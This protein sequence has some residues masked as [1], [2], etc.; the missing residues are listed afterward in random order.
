L[1]DGAHALVG[2][3]SGERSAANEQ[4]LWVVASGDRRDRLLDSLAMW[5]GTDFSGG[6]A[7]PRIARSRLAM[8]RSSQP[9]SQARCA[10]APFWEMCS[11]AGKLAQTGQ[12]AMPS[13]GSQR[14]VAARVASSTV[15]GALML[16]LPPAGRR[17]GEISPPTFR[18]SAMLSTVF[19]SCRRLFGLVDEPNEHPSGR[20]LKL[21]AAGGDE[22]VDGRLYLLIRPT[23]EPGEVIE[24][25]ALVDLVALAQA[26]LERLGAGVTHVTRGPR[27][28]LAAWRAS[29]LSV[30]RRHRSLSPEPGSPPGF[31][32]CECRTPA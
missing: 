14:I 12:S 32:R 11:V 31:G 15:R 13:L 16:T 9:W 22:G 28:D 20:G 4:P 25:G 21:D 7:A 30:E 23:Q 29:S 17:G 18:A 2:R 1:D 8:I 10:P 19:R 6:A 5:R 26:Q 3:H 24:L 27:G